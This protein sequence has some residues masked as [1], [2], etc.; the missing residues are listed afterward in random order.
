MALFI[1]FQIC[2]ILPS[3]DRSLPVTLQ[4]LALTN[5]FI[6]TH[7]YAEKIM[8]KNANGSAVISQH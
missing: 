4:P 5:I 3:V 1:V 2:S 8:F 7:G 6:G